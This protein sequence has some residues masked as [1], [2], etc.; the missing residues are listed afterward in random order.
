MADDDSDE[1]IL[2]TAVRLGATELWRK[3]YWAEFNGFNSAFVD[4]WGNTLDPVDQG[5]FGS[6]RAG[7]VDA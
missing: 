7:G 4:P 1:R 2:E 5:W 3:H 6:C